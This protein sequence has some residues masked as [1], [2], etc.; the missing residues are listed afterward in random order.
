MGLDNPFYSSAE[1]DME[2]ID[3]D[4]IAAE[5]RSKSRITCNFAAI[6]RGR[7]ENG[8][9][10]EEN[11]NVMNMSAGGAYLILNREI[12]VG[13]ELA[14]RIALPTG[15]LKTGTSKLATKG[16]V[17]RGEEINY[18]SYGIAVKFTSYRFL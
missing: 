17:L 3:Q 12:Q 5:R 18:V 10:F 11:A 13:D 15:S 9:E 7:E 4:G 8:R 16:I 2:W 1:S 14:V 6:V